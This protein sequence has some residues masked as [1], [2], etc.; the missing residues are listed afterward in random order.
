MARSARLERVP[1]DGYVLSVLRPALQPIGVQSMSKL[2]GMW[3]DVRRI[4]GGEGTEE[5]SVQTR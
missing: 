1:D 4:R 5:Y 3:D 2:L